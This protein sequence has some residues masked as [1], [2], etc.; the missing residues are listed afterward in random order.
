MIS[1]MKMLK[2]TLAIASLGLLTGIAPSTSVAT[3]HSDAMP[4]RYCELYGAVYVEQTAAFADYK[5]YLEEIESFAKMVV[6]KED[7]E[8]FADRPGFW[9]FTDVKA[10]ANFTIAFEQNQGLADFSMAYTDFRSAAGCQ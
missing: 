7:V 10:F 5:V 1:A 8:S 9:Y 2:I 6:Y 3:D 4:P